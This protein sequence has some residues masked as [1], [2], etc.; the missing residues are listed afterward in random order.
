MRHGV[1][2]FL[3]TGGGKHRHVG[4]AGATA[5]QQRQQAKSENF[6]HGKVHR[7]QEKKEFRNIDENITAIFCWSKRCLRAV[8]LPLAPNK[9]LL[10]SI[11]YIS[12]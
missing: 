2:R 8:H 5:Q 6:F 1:Q 4:G 7:A 10:L 9:I 11:G 3:Q 12:R